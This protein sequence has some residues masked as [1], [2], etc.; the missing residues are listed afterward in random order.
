MLDQ[1]K[2]LLWLLLAI[3]SFIFGVIGI[4]LPVVPQ[5]PF[6]LLG[7]YSL[8]KFSTRFHNWMINTKV[9]RK[10]QKILDEKIAEAQAQSENI[11]QAWYKVLW[12][13]FLLLAKN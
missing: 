5:V 7:F 2:R 13:K 9:Y 11:K 8:S 12:L 4:L 3:F 6:F 10:L 1:V